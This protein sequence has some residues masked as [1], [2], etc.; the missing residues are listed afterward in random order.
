M[1]QLILR[2]EKIQIRDNCEDVF[3][4]AF[5]TDKT[6]D[7]R[8]AVI[9]CPGGGYLSISESEG[10]PVAHS[11]AAAGFRPFVLHY[12][13]MEQARYC[14]GQPFRPVEELRHA[15]DIVTDN[16]EKYSVD[17]KRLSLIGFSAGGH[18]AALY[19]TRKDKAYIKPQSL[20]LS[21]PLIDYRYLGEKWLYMEGCDRIDLRVLSNKKIFGLKQ[22][23]EKQLES[24]DVKNYIMSGMPPTFMW[25]SKDDHIIALESSER[26]ADL[27]LKNGNSCEL[28]VYEKGIHG[29][30]F[31]DD[32]WFNTAM[33]WMKEV[34]YG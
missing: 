33:K 20:I 19:C 13:T 26:F 7:S 18:L 10:D 30:P 11:F 1:E 6:N 9:I 12:S 34:V 24:F 3:L 22:P 5:V 23:G 29:Q 15:F 27:M 32:T 17:K 28:A 25:H 31:Y 21:Y 4:R 14:E 16:H 2:T 8:P